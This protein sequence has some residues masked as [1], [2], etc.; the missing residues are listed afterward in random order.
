MGASNILLLVGFITWS[1]TVSEGI[2][3]P[4]CKEDFKVIGRHT[5]RCK[6]RVTSSEGIPLRTTPTAPVVDLTASAVNKTCEQPANVGL[7]EDTCACGRRCKGRRG[8]KAHQRSCALFK[9]LLNKDYTQGVHDETVPTDSSTTDSPDNKNENMCIADMEIKPGIRLPKSPSRWPKQM[10][11]FDR[12]SL[13][14]TRL[15]TLMSM[16]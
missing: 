6:A 10:H 11:T 5:W 4:Y 16:S 8:L 9:T 12:Y 2:C 15:T 14:Q 13:S 3:C 7:D 1:W